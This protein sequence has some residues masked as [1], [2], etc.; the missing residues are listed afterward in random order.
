MRRAPYRPCRRG[1]PSPSGRRSS[2]TRTVRCAAHGGTR[3]ATCPTS[4]SCFRPRGLCSARA[5]PLPRGRDQRHLAGRPAR[6]FALP[7]G[8][9]PRPRRG[10]AGRSPPDA[11]PLLAR[12]P[13]ARARPGPLARSVLLSA[14]GRS[15]AELPGLAL[16]LRLLAALGPVRDGRW[17]ER[18][19]APRLRPS[20]SR[21]LRLAAGARA[22]ARACAGGRPRLRDRAVPRGAERRAPARADL[23]LARRRPLGRR[24]RA[25]REQLVARGLGR[26]ARLDPPFRTGAPGAR[27]D[28]VL[29]LLR[30][31]ASS[32]E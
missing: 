20:R 17:L 28:S 9:R 29:H 25:P 27:R 7:L 30:I 8:G 32:A 5:P 19:A 2:S 3:R 10:L 16:R 21:S 18:P 6:A 12:R 14:R 11:V 23:G 4:T 26:R 31:R 15:P 22:A 1:T 24:A 13:S